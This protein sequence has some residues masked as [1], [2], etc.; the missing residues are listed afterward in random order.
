MLETSEGKQWLAE[1]QRVRTQGPLRYVLIRW[2]L[3]YGLTAGVVTSLFVTWGSGSMSLR[4]AA[5]NTLGWVIAMALGGALAWVLSER[6]Y[7]RR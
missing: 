6:K 4:G 3:A 2:G 5:M 7:H 1:W